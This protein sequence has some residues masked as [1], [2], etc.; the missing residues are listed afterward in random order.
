MKH[1]LVHILCLYSIRN[2]MFLQHF[3]KTWLWYNCRLAILSI[4]SNTVKVT[5][6]IFGYLANKK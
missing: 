6:L 4:D 5:G 2:C 1:I 3:D